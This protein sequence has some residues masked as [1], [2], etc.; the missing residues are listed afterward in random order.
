[1]PRRRE[2]TVTIQFPFRH[3]QPAF[4]VAHLAAGGNQVKDASG[5]LA[6]GQPFKNVAKQGFV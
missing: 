3:A 2:A 1:M 5:G 4:K 6:G